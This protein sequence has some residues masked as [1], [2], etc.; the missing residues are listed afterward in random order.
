MGASS[1]W[2]ETPASPKTSD[3][4]AANIRSGAPAWAR[5]RATASSVAV[6]PATALTDSVGSSH[7]AGT[8]VGA[9]R[10]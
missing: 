9:A 3:D 1:D 5:S 2:G 7:E 8:N 10:W 6:P 4:A